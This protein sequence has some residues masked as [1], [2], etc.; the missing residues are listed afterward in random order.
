MVILAPVPGVVMPPGDLSNDQFPVA[1]KPLKATLPDGAL[2]VG[3]VM[4][5]AL[6]AAGVEG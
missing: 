3:W 4:V 2:Q 5:P 1:G 6:G